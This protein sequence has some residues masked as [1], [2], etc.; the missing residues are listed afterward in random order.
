ML[1]VGRSMFKSFSVLL[2]LFI[3]LHLTSM[4]LRIMHQVNDIGF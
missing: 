3:I 4:V 1:N 2:W